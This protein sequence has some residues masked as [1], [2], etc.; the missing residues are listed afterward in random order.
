MST[1]TKRQ[2]AA[3]HV[4]RLRTLCEKILDMSRDW[5]DVDQFCM[6]DLEA[7]AD[8]AE[9]VAINMIASK[10]DWEDA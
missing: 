8:K 4:R 1:P 10:A 7:L 5:E 2:L 9:E 3:R 6:S